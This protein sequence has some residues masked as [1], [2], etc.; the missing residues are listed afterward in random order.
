[1]KADVIVIPH[2]SEDYDIICDCEGRDADDVAYNALKDW[3]YEALGD[4][5]K[6]YVAQNVTLTMEVVKGLLAERRHERDLAYERETEE[7]ER[8]LLARLK[9]KYES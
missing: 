6:V 2:T 1:M 3:S 8:E 4:I 5:F 9:A 7:R